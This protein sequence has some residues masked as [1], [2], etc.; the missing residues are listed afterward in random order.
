MTRKFK[1]GYIEKGWYDTSTHRYIDNEYSINIAKVVQTDDYGKWQ[2]EDEDEIKSFGG[3]KTE[4]E[5]I[6]ELEKEGIKELYNE[7]KLVWTKLKY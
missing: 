1:R 6:Q 2:D 5:A 3:Y 7:N 4:Q